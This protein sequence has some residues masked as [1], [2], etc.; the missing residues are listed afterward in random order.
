MKEQYVGDIN[1][2]RK[3]ALLRA[4]SAGGRHRV[5]VCWM[6]T[7]SDGRADGNLLGYLT[8]PERFRAFDPE[9][10]DIL[11]AVVG[12]DGG[13]R[14]IA[15]EEADAIPNARY[16]NAETPQ[17]RDEREAWLDE[18]RSA[19][20]GCN[21]VFLDPDNGLAVASTGMGR[22]SSPKYVFLDEVAAFYGAGQSVLIYQHYPRIERRAFEIACAT[23]LSSI[24]PNAQLWRFATG[25]VVFLLILHPDAPTTLVEAV[26]QTASRWPANFIHGARLDPEKSEQYL[27]QQIIDRNQ[28]A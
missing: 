28:P 25:H 3:Y 6:L 22:K 19:L 21:L 14:L 17:R 9:L 26:D 13:R 18:C 12:R 23:S 15:I 7:P 11:R 5:G 27:A 10:F 8:K 20:E 16:F 2:Y 4:L 1:D 24:A